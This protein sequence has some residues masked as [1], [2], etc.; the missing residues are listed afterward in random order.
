MRTV[1]V[2]ILL[3]I[4][5]LSCSILTKKQEIYKYAIRV[6]AINRLYL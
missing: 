5:F 4:S 3:I 1:V 6:K 2:F